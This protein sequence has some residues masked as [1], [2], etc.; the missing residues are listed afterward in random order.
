M[1]FMQNL[2]HLHFISQCPLHIWYVSRNEQKDN[3]YIGQD[4]GTDIVS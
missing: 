3:Y 2:Y 4:D 1:Y